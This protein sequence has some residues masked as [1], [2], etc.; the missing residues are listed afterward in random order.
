MCGKNITYIQIMDLVCRNKHDGAFFHILHDC[1][2]PNICNIELLQKRKG[3]AC[4]DDWQSGWMRLLAPDSQRITNCDTRPSKDHCTVSHALSRLLPVQDKPSDI[5]LLQRSNTRMFENR[6]FHALHQQLSKKGNV[7]VYTGNES[8]VSTVNIF[9][10][11]RYLVG[12]HGAGLTNA[13]FMQNRTRI[14]EISTFN[15]LN[16][17]VPWRSN[18]EKVTKYGT[19]KTHLMRV[20][21]QQLLKANNAEYR[22]YDSDHFVKD[23]KYVSLT[24]SDVQRIVEFV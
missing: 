6:T 23:L 11:A 13:Y 2:I 1:I 7:I 15:D 5:V 21:I 10:R 19:F 8:P 20:P 3:A 24:H 9:Q 17:S 16:N 12:Y 18:M 4:Y 22:T 14:L